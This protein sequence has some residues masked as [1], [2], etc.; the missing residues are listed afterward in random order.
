MAKLVIFRGD[1]QLT[2]RELTEQTVRI[3]RGAQNDIILEDPGKGVSRNHAELRFEDGRYTLVDLQSQNGI[4]VSGERVPSVVLE[5]GVSAALGPFRLMVEAPAVSPVAAVTPVPVDPATEM[6]HLSSRTAT[7]L[8]LDNLGP[9]PEKPSQGAPPSARPPAV[10]PTVAKPPAAKAP[11]QK[12]S[13]SPAQ[14]LPDGEGAWYADPRILAGAVAVV[15]LVTLSAFIGYKLMGGS[16]QK[17]VFDAAA[18]QQLVDAGRCPEALEQHIKPALQADPNNQQALALQNRCNSAAPPATSIVTSSIP[19]G[20]TADERLSQVEPLVIAN[21]AADCQR[22]LDTINA[23]LGE[24]PNNER[25]KGLLAKATTCA[26]PPARGGP[27][28]STPLEKPA[29]AVPP[30]QG[31][32]EV[33]QGETEKAYRSRMTAMRKKYDD[34]V[35]I[36]TS[37]N[38]VLA[39]RALDEIVPEVPSGYLDLAARRDT[40]RSGIRAE[41]KSTFGRAQA[42]E[43]RSDFDVAVDLY[44]RAHQLDQSLLVEDAIQRISAAVRTKC[45]EALV[46]LAFD[47]RNAGAITAL[48]DAVKILPATEACAAQAKE[49]LQQ[50]K[51]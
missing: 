22:A 6:T 13:P 33:I 25:A 34:A 17:N 43:A 35:A 21:V 32:L 30:A 46:E 16:G 50:L 36:L 31:G 42:A 4:W 51:K 2:A 49:R 29:V 27:P 9:P 20:P 7:P 10:Q 19:A 40:A 12:P 3:G 41:A 15:A 39:M 23:V 38:Y 11:V 44:R 18:A 5:P 26:N 8:E 1:A 45:K 47:S 48:Q 14:K 24:D 37:Q 28:V